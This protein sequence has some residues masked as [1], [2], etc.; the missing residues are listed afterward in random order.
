MTTCVKCDYDSGA[1]MA[2]SYSITVRCVLPSLNSVGGNQKNNPKYRGWRKF[3]E[4]ALSEWVL[5]V[6]AATAR[7]RL[8]VYRMY[9]KGRRKYDRINMAA[10]CKSLLDVLVTTGVLYDDNEAWLQDNYEQQRSPDGGDYVV[11][12]V[13]DY[14]QE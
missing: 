14:A 10:G 3:W 7:R 6:P 4:R 11:L 9:G 8:N 1:V 12:T 13:E 5:T 2:A